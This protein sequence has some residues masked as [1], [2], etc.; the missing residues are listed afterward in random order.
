M[1]CEECK[2]AEAVVVIFSVS[3]V[4]EGVNGSFDMSGKDDI[5]PSAFDDVLREIDLTK[6]TWQFSD[7]MYLCQSQ[8]PRFSMYQGQNRGRRTYTH[9]VKCFPIPLSSPLPCPLPVSKFHEHHVSI[10]SF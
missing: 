9:F 2:P 7:Y 5:W 1:E 4:M 3:V 6:T 8:S 10:A